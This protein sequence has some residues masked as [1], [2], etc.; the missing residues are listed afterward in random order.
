MDRSK[1]SFV[2]A[3]LAMLGLLPG[4]AELSSYETQAPA[5]S[6]A[7]ASDAVLAATKVF[8]YPGKDQ[9]AQQ[10]DRDRY[11]CYLWAVEQTGFDPSQL[12]LAPHQRVEVVAVP[13]PGAETTAGA[14]AGAVIGAV[15]SPSR[16][17][18]EGAIVGAMIGGLAG[19]AS[20][21][22]RAHSAEE[23]RRTYEENITAQHERQSNEYRR[24]LTACLEGRGYT[25]K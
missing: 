24:A 5:A 10:L 14:I 2:L 23:L 15:V 11:E 25:V 16:H 4:C 12:G 8:V 20:E 21:A 19:A 13:T 3:P 7:P 6:T 9:S 22:E 1:L 18:A 17:A